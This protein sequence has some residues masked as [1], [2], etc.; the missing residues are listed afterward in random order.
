VGG[1]FYD[2]ACLEDGAI[3][4]AIGDVSGRGISAALIMSRV[5]LDMGRAIRSGV[6]PSKVLENVNP[7]LIDEVGE[8]FVTASCFSLDPRSRLLTVASAGHLPLMVRRA[9]GEVFG[10]G[11]ASGAPL[12]MLPCRYVDERLELHPSDILIL[13]TDGL[14]EALDR[15]GDRMGAYCLHAVVSSA[16]HDPGAINAGILAAME[17]SNGSEPLDDVTLVALQIESR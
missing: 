12:G 13:M 14:V 16:P 10:F 11:E 6:A 15:P 2:L 17:E 8:T 9:T 1:D 3:G 5:S 4:G 7:T